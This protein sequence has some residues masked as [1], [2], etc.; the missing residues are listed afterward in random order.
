MSPN[1]LFES[2]RL[3]FRN[4]LKSDL[5][6]L[7]A[8]NEDPGVMEFF[9]KTLSP[10]ESLDLLNRLT[11]HFEQYGHTYYAVELKTSK[12]FI[13]FIG[14]AY[15]EYESP[16]TPNVDIGWRL[17]PE[18]WG[19]GYATEGAQRCLQLAF[20]DL[21]ISKIVST[22]T[23]SNI[24]SENVMKKIGMKKMG[25][26]NHPKLADYPEIQKCVWYQITQ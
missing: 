12:K 11:N 7:T 21:H 23:V 17:L 6:S 10:D 9:P 20:E 13:G 2:E 22:C 15:Q 1:Y 14:L 16:L 19:K 3:G 18:A 5:E 26:F 8:M 24:P 4:W 25:Y